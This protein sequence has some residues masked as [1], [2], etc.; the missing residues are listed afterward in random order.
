MSPGIFRF[1]RGVASLSAAIVLFASLQA[2]QTPDGMEIRPAWKA[3]LPK[4]G[5]VA[6]GFPMLTGAQ[7]ATIFEPRREDGAYNH[8]S[9]L[10]WHRGKFYAMW[11]NHPFTEDGPGQRVLIATAERPDRWSSWREL[12]PA[13]GPVEA[14]RPSGGPRPAFA[15]AF[16][17]IVRGERLF[18]VAAV[19]TAGPIAREVLPSGELG[20]IFRLWT[21]EAALPFT[22]LAARDPGIAALATELDGLIGTPEFWPWWDFWD[23]YP[24]PDTETGR[25][26]VEPTVHCARDGAY[27]MLLRDSETAG[28]YS[29]RVF[30]SVSRDGGKTWPAAQPTDIPDSP[31]RRDAVR[32]DDGTI[33]LLG[34]QVAPVFDN[35][36]TEKHYPRDPLTVAVSRDGYVFERVYALR[37]SLPKAMRVSGVKG[38]GV[39]A[40]YPSAIA[41]DGRLYVLHTVGKEDVAISWVPLRDLGL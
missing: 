23:R 38:R 6:L 27:V 31:S 40:Q 37:W 29:H 8:H 3:P 39:G 2:A 18:A 15:S 28:G 41:H 25:K 1:A 35:G 32:L 22:T 17:W 24:E 19:N 5:A 13:P 7:H 9:E 20:P 36:D 34:N 12:F 14:E 30:M 4:A 33:L 11:S 10:I 21:R 16:T 26:L